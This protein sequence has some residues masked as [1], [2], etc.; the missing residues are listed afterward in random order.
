M[1]QSFTTL[2]IKLFAG[3]T[4]LTGVGWAAQNQ[5]F[6][7]ADHSLPALQQNQP[8]PFKYSTRIE[9]QLPGTNQVILKIYNIL[10]QEIKTLVNEIQ[11]EGIYTVEW[12]G[13]D[14][15]GSEVAGGIYFC[16]LHTGDLVQTRR[17]ILLK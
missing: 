16:R 17:I 4:F 11:N 6:S 8:N 10:G 12:D 14:W 3:A 7:A 5:I 2:L 15:Q 9:Y 1:K 13:T